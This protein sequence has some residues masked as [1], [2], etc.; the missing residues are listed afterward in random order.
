MKAQALSELQELYPAVYTAERA[1]SADPTWW[2]SRQTLGRAQLNLGEIKSAINSFQKAVHIRPDISEL[3]I[4]DLKWS[5]DL[6][7]NLTDG[8]TVSDEELSFHVR[9][10]MRVGIV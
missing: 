5:L 3:W 8:K 10:K 1:V 4:D 7:Q 2:E 9:E 6:W